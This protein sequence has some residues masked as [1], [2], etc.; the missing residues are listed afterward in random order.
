MGRNMLPR[1][2]KHA[3]GTSRTKVIQRCGPIPGGEWKLT[4]RQREYLVTASYRGKKSVKPFRLGSCS[5]VLPKAHLVERKKEQKN[6]LVHIRQAA[7]P[8]ILN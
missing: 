8:E 4:V 6:S 5:L 2:S 1:G 7:C 3:L